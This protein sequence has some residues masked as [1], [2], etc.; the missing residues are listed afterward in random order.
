ML[1][2]TRRFRAICVA[3]VPEAATLDDTGWRELEQIVTRAV[4]SRPASVRRQLALFVRALDLLALVRT[5]HTLSR[6]APRERWMLL[7]DLSKSKLLLVRRG[8]W[9]VRTLVFMGYYARPATAGAIGYGA[10]AA[11]WSARRRSTAGS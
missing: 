2:G 5:R 6:L 10:S 9:G 1:G 8:I 3:V 4:A 11:G 7:D